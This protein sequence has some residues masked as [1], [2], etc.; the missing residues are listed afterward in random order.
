MITILRAYKRA[1]AFLLAFLVVAYSAFRL[2][3]TDDLGRF[4]DLFNVLLS[5]ILFASQL[6][7]IWRVSDLGGGAIPP[8]KAPTRSGVGIQRGLLTQL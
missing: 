7:W 4:Y 1:I 2:I 8:W 6:F 3:H 5:V